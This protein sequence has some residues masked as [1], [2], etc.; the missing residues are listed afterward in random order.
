[1]DFITDLP[2]SID[3]T[4]GVVYDSILVI[5]DRYTKISKYILY[6]KTT[7]AEDLADLFL[8]NW[9]KDQGLPANIISDRGSVFTSK[10][11]S[12][13]CYHLRIRR[14]LSTAFY[15]QTDGQT[16]RQNQ[17]IETWL[18]AYVYYIQDD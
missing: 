10:F 3:K 2:R 7:S 5:V 12:A 13:L 4:T 8:K 15:P 1:M 6:K 17:V 16:E 11:W 9:F 14:G 18:R